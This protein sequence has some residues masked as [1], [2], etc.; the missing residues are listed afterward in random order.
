MIKKIVMTAL[1]ALSLGIVASA[2][3]GALPVLG[4]Q[5]DVRAVAM[6]GVYAPG[7]EGHLYS[8]PTDVFAGCCR[9]KLRVHAL[10]GLTPERGN[11]ASQMATITGSY[12][13]DKHAIFVGA[14][15]LGFV[16]QD[17]ITPGGMIRGQINPR[18]WTIDLGYAYSFSRAFA[19]Y[20]RG[21]FV[22][23]YNSLNADVLTFSLGGSYRTNFQKGD[24][25]VASLL[26][27]LSLDNVGGKY[28]YGKN[29]AE[30]DLPTSVNASLAVSFLKDRSLTLGVRSASFLKT[31]GGERAILIG[32]GAQYR[33]AKIMAVRGGYIRQSDV[34]VWSLGLGARLGKCRIDASYDLHSVSDFNYLRLGFGVA[35]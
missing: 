25:I 33:F 11:V 9:T 7:D 14:R 34:D 22:Q 8:S 21:G 12:R 4:L 20:A 17:Y 1:S 10:L 30:Y 29:G 31:Q 3:S 15:Y 32:V 23:S 26:A 16:E 24:Q 28:H 6:G 27:T 2:Q 35:L 5:Q 19:V 13:M 18:D